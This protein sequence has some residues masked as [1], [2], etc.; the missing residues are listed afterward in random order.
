[1]A[2]EQ[3]STVIQNHVALGRFLVSLLRFAI[4]SVYNFGGNARF[5]WDRYVYPFLVE[6]W[7]LLAHR[8]KAFVEFVAFDT[9][10][11][12]STQYEDLRLGIGGFF[13]NASLV[14]IYDK[15]GE[16]I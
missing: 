16:E 5:V 1:M 9:D 4:V 8:V 7:G 10:D 13:A 15:D 3:P 2:T 14:N 11:A 6:L 12:I